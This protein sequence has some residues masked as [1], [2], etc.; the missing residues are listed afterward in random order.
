V[1]LPVRLRSLLAGTGRRF[2]PA[3]FSPKDPLW[4][5]YIVAGIFGADRM[6]T[7]VLKVSIAIPVVAIG[8]LVLWHLLSSLAGTLSKKRRKFRPALEPRPPLFSP[9]HPTRPAID[10]APAVSA[11]SQLAA[12]IKNDPERLEQA[13]ATLV[14]TLAE[15]YLELADSWLRQGEP[16]RAAASL[17]KLLQ[18]C[19]G[20][21][22]AQLAEDRLRKLDEELQSPS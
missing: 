1:L 21:R 20:T 17:Q 18:S 22:H 15:M 9:K 5:G 6:D 14:D 8:G 16:R 10:P 2:L 7:W 13:C 4:D 3:G 12:Q 19:P 11:P